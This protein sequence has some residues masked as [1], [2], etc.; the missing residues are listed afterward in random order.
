MGKNY[1]S[2]NDSERIEYAKRKKNHKELYDRIVD[3]E[4]KK[5]KSKY[6]GLS[7]S[8]DIADKTKDG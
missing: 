6:S 7:K 8:K 3:E 2:L 5:L 4:F 1:D